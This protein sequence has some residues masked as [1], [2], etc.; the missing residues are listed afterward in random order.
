MFEEK[1]ETEFEEEDDEIYFNDKHN[2]LKIHQHIRGS[3]VPSMAYKKIAHI[4]NK[5]NFL[6]NVGQVI[7]LN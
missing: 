6:G 2:F 4:E 3:R 1:A 7:N 5:D